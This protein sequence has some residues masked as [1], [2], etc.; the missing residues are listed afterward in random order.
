MTAA[1]GDSA[2]LLDD[3]SVAGPAAERRT[4]TFGVAFQDLLTPVEIRIYGTNALASNGAWWFQDQGSTPG[5]RVLG[6]L[7][8]VQAVPEPSSAAL[9]VVGGLALAI[10]RRAGSTRGRRHP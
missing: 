1:A 4:I 5:L 10:R 7:T 3:A 2:T 8:R 9:L 6:D